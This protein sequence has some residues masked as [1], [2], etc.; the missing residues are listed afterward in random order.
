MS[1]EKLVTITKRQ[2]DDLPHLVKSLTKLGI[3]LGSKGERL[4]GMKGPFNN[5][6]DESRLFVLVLESDEK[7]NQ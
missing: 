6:Q 1:K 7:E 3:S 2:M 5:D 4:I